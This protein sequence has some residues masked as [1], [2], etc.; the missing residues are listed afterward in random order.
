MVHVRPCGCWLSGRVKMI[1]PFIPMN[2][3]SSNDLSSARVSVWCSRFDVCLYE[4]GKQIF[5]YQN[6]V[7]VDCFIQFRRTLRIGVD[8]RQST[9]TERR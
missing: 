2:L 3:P 1:S 9:H 5:R 8:T 6:N 7:I 4:T